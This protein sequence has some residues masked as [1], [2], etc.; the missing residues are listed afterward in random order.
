MH[1]HISHHATHR[2]RDAA[3]SLGIAGP[4]LITASGDRTLKVLVLRRARD[5]QSEQETATQGG[6]NT[7]ETASATRN[8]DLC[9]SSDEPQGFVH[10]G[11]PAQ[12]NG[13]EDERPDACCKQGTNSVGGQIDG[14]VDGVNG[15]GRSTSGTETWAKAKPEAGARGRSSARSRPN[16]G[17]DVCAKG[18][19]EVATLRGHTDIVFAVCSSHVPFAG[20]VLLASA[21]VDWTVK[22]WR[23]VKHGDLSAWVCEKSIMDATSGTSMGV[24][25]AFHPQRA[26]ILVSA[27]RDRVVVWELVQGNM[28]CADE[29]MD[30]VRECG[31]LQE[32]RGHVA[33][34]SAV[35][36]RRDG[37]LLA[38][39]DRYIYIYI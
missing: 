36:F 22:I 25:I 1:V 21:A 33:D 4:V 16:T 26:E 11:V 24:P 2:T 30:V 19:V 27:Y 3:S 35:C 14:E 17:G 9:L 18:F 8:D 37:E 7:E 10:G 38:S 31:K 13:D 20:N 15:A 28:E 39:C 34:V 29:D 32:L 23:M 6:Q 12:G 5:S